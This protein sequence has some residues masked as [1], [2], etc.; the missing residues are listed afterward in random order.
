[1]KN[2]ILNYNQ[3]YVAG[4]QSV[5][6]KAWN[7]S[8]MARWGFPVP[9]GIVIS[10]E[11]YVEIIGRPNVAKLVSNAANLVAE[12]LIQPHAKE[13]LNKLRNA[14]G[15]ETL[16]AENIEKIQNELSIAAASEVEFAIRS[17]ATGEDGDKNAFAGIHESFLNVV[18][19]DNVVSSILKCFAS[20]WTPHAVA[21]RRRFDLPD[22]AVNAAVLI[23][24]MVHAEN[25]QEPLAAGVVFTADP[26]D[27]R[28]DTVVIE[29]T[30]GMGDK[31]VNG[32][33]TPTTTKVRMKVD[34]YEFVDGG[35]T[36]MPDT[37]MNELIL[38][39][40]R[41]HWAFSD[42]ATPQDIEWAYD[43]KQIIILQVRPVTVLPRRTYDGLRAQP[44]IWSNANFKE[45]LSGILSPMGWS[46]IP[47]FSAEHFFDIQ[48]LSNYSEPKGMQIVKRFEGRAYVDV[49]IIQ[50]SGWD[51]WGILP[52]ETN[53][54][55]GGFQPE[56]ELPSELAKKSKNGT[57]K[58]L[59]LMKV[60]RAVWRGQKTLP[61]QLA[62]IEKRAKKFIKKDLSSLSNQELLRLWFSLSDEQWQVPFM[63]ANSMGS[64][65]LG[66][67][68]Q[69]GD[70]YISSQ[71][72]EPIISGLMT[73]Q[74]NVVSAQHAYELHELVAKHGTKG[75]G[76]E[77]ALEAWLE[78]YGHRGYGEFDIANPRWGDAKDEMRQFAQ[79]MGKSIH[80]SATANQANKQ[81]ENELKKL[82]FL[83]GKA[84]KW[85]MNKAVVGFALREQGKSTLIASIGMTRHIV[86]EYGQR[87]FNEGIIE[88]QNDIFLLSF[89]DLWMIAAGVWG[90]RGAIEIISD[91]KLQIVSW[92]ASKAPADV[93]LQNENSTEEIQPQLNM[94]GN[95]IKGVGVSSGI[96]RGM[97]RKLDD[98]SN[99]NILSN[100]GI[101]VARSTDPSWTPLFLSASGIVVEVGG[102]LSHSAIVAREFGLPAV[103]N[104]SGC[105]EAIQQGD[106]LMVNGNDGVVE[107]ISQAD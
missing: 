29:A 60:L 45:V 25:S 20:L 36:L 48:H 43:G 89:A 106:E 35:S 61:N 27:G 50:Y 16:S 107:V 52:A 67:A 31:L 10:T 92:Q 4:V 1:M 46:L 51:A 21:Y 34:G 99:A 57:N 86:L 24:E 41:L 18:G 97:A 59:A 71:E 44:E 68:R 91:R 75:D 72:L 15:T 30:K 6:G 12:D 3:A 63:L 62:D 19:I 80:N 42:G 90:G 78:K 64:V 11:I 79:K 56:I 39:A 58:S 17:S 13:L 65:W 37:A 83:V 82:P 84:L 33:I 8:R 23:C 100:G 81:A 69:L 55:F 5:G 14:I 94:A 32:E 85:L 7:M 74:G 47:L 76:F 54:A 22:N 73:G 105:F 101:L 93:I 28:R 38:L 98:P 49:S 103:V 95:I 2:V 70:K 53:R 87:L 104:A 102:Y 26:T 66:M 96:A 77:Q 88:Q 40:W 9:N